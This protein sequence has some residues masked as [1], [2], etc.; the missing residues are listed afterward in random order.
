MR[1][2]TL[3]QTAFYIRTKSP[4][5]SK[6]E[7]LKWF[8]YRTLL[9]FILDFEQMNSKLR[10][11]EKKIIKSEMKDNAIFI[12]T[13]GDL[14]NLYEI[15]SEKRQE[16]YR[17]EKFAQNPIIFDIGAHIGVYSIKKV[18]QHCNGI[19]YAI[20]P[21]ERNF[22]KLIN[23]IGTNN[24]HNVIPIQVALLNRAGYGELS[25]D[26]FKSSQYSLFKKGKQYQRVKVTTLDDLIKELKPPSVD[27]IK[28]D[29]EG[30]EYP[31]LIGGVQTL[32]K[33]CPFLI[34]ETHPQN[35]DDCDKK[36][37]EYLKKVDYSLKTVKRT[38]GLTIFAYKQKG[39]RGVSE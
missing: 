21:E 29:T 22:K 26:E 11:V 10:T 23:N 19:V 4:I 27:L 3:R 34:I 7:I 18:F 24:L 31:I 14:T 16:K 37:M 5:S 8:L 25:I 12:H 33:Y 32:E 2:E 17:P 38:V 39:H 36:I 35:Y 13:I 30:A 28:I 20:E 1:L 15:Y 6:L 9:R